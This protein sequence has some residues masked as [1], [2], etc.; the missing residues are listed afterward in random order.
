MLD[1]GADVIEVGG[2]STRP[3]ARSVEAA[4]E[5]SRVMPV[6]R[7]IASSI[8]A[9]WPH[10]RI[11]IDTVKSSVADAA[12]GEGAAIVNDVSA[13]RLDP[14]LAEV[15]ARHRAC[16]VLMH[17]RGGVED[18]AGYERAVYDAEGVVAEVVGELKDAAERAVAAGVA[19]SEIVLDPGLGFSKRPA[20]SVEV[21]AHVPVLLE[22]GFEVMVGASRKRFI[23]ELTGVTNP[24]GRI[25]GTIGANVA[26]LSLGATWFRVHDVRQNREAL[27]V[28]HAILEARA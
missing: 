8:A 4:E 18:M 13:L 19:R 3:G 26:A 17:S 15:C 16:L 6:I 23:G 7:G 27:D 25:A 14:R 5:A 2:E 9:R 21:L 10:A 28:A 22:L 11:A 24:A 12:L 20:H 1:E